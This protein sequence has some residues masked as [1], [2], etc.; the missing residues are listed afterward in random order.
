MLSIILKALVVGEAITKLTIIVKAE[1]F[2]DGVSHPFV[3]SKYSSFADR[4]F[5]IA[6]GVSFCS[7]DSNFAQ[8]SR[9]AGIDW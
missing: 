2:E 8:V 1:I 3:Q 4:A 5:V 7:T 6:K 9:L